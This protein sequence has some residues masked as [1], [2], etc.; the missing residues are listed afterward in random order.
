MKKGGGILAY[1][2]DRLKVERITSMDENEL[3]ITWLQIHLYKSNRP[4]LI[5]AVYRPPSST[6]ETDARLELS[7]EAAYLRNQK[8]HVFGDFNMNFVDPA[9]KKNID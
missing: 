2:V 4:I 5:G 7:I 9:Y 3:E 6:V 8:L 1:I